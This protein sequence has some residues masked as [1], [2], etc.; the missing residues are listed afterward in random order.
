MGPVQSPQDPLFFLH[1]AQID[2]Y[3]TA[4]QLANTSYR[5][6]AYSGYLPASLTNASAPVVAAS[7]TDLLIFGSLVPNVTVS[8]VMNTRG[9]LLCYYVRVPIHFASDPLRKVVVSADL[10]LSSLLSPSTPDRQTR[11]DLYCRLYWFTL[12]LPHV[13]FYLPLSSHFANIIHCS[14]CA[15]TR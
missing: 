2:R 12:T 14:I 8:Q 10:C 7:L 6:N 1:H 15:M 3:W 4:W 11:S 9:S 5:T 13:L